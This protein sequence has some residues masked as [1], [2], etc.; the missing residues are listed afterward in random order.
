MAASNGG[1][2]AADGRP[3]DALLDQIMAG[4][5]VLS[6]VIAASLAQVDGEV[7]LPQLRVLVVAS[8]RGA[9]G[10]NEVAKLLGVHPSNATR[11]V[12]RLVAGGLATRQQDPDNRRQRQLILTED[13]R[14]LVAT[15][16]GH[17]RE[18]LVQLV[19]AMSAAQQ[20]DLARALG[21]LDRAQGARS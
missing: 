21:A 4:A 17:R 9:L 16:M 3:P 15:V 18:S 8:E 6:G 13:G 5:R 1:S 7:T 14:R 10:L 19:A 2:A 11:L 12:D 20:R